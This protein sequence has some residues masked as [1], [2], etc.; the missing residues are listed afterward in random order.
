MWIIPV[1]ILV[2]LENNACLR[3]F[4]FIIYSEYLPNI[5]FS[6]IVSAFLFSGTT[7]E[8]D[9]RK[10]EKKVPIQCSTPTVRRSLVPWPP[11]R[12]S[13]NSSLQCD[14]ARC[15]T[16]R[17]LIPL[18]APYSV[19]LYVTHLSLLG[20]LLALFYNVVILVVVRVFGWF[21]LLLV[22]SDANVIF[23][24]FIHTCVRCF[25]I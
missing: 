12:C 18:F 23:L 10:R 11:S 3:H 16:S 14:A 6:N 19:R 1:N 22:S 25:M 7:W 8:V 17:I 13:G 15:F 21:V 2:I 20:D 24:I 5:S 4:C 9:L